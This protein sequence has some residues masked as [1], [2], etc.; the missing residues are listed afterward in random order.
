M[1]WLPIS[2]RK[3]LIAGLFGGALA[4][5]WPHEGLALDGVTVDGRAILFYTDDVGIF[6]ATRRMSR[7]DDPTQPALDTRLTNKG[8]DVV[9]E[10]DMT[11]GKSV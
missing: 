2:I 1:N 10:P 3:A 8:S 4:L 5:G 11:I 9:F 7:D 6:S